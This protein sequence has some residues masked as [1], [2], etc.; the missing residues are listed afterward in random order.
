MLIM[1][2]SFIY[3]YLQNYLSFSSIKNFICYEI[4][5]LINENDV[6]NLK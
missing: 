4:F 5:N 6:D 3:N 2:V 1:Y